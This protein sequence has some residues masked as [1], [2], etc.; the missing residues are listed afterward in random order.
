[1]M[2]AI[3]SV[4]ETFPPLKDSIEDSSSLRRRT[5]SSSEA[6]SVEAVA[7]ES[8]PE[9]DPALGCDEL[10]APKEILFWDSAGH[11]KVESRDSSASDPMM[12]P[13]L[14]IEW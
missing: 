1:M 5:R 8:T 14:I 6:G 10:V 4:F 13:W 2:S 7:L 9:D 3:T 12:M 11:R